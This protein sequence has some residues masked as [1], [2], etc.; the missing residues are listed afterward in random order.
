MRLAASTVHWIYHSVLHPDGYALARVAPAGEDVSK[1]R[2]KVVVLVCPLCVLVGFIQALS[3]CRDI[4]RNR[5]HWHS[6]AIADIRDAEVKPTLVRVG[7]AMWARKRVK[8]RRRFLNIQFGS[9]G[10]ATFL[11]DEVLI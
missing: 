2:I 8:A 11:S 9:V 10:L 6:G 7:A 1:F 4:P 3:G 5:E